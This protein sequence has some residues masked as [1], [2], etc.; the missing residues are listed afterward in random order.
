MI[1][2]PQKKSPSASETEE[3]L[4]SA[5]DKKKLNGITV[6]ADAVEFSQALTSGT[7]VGYITINGNKYT[8]YAPTNTDTTYG[9][10]TSST[11]GLVKSGTDITVDSSGNVSVNDDSHNHVISNIDG[12]QSALDGKAASSHAHDDRYYTESEVDTKLNGKAATSHGN[13][14]PATQTANNAVFLRNDNTWQTVTPANIGAAASSH[15]HS[16]MKGATSSAAGA[17]GLVPAPAAGDQEKFLRADGTWQEAG[18]GGGTSGIYVGTCD[19]DAATAEKAVTVDGDFNLKVGA[20]VMVRFKNTNTAT[21]SYNGSTTGYITLNVNNTG[22]Y[23]IYAEGHDVN[24]NAPYYAKCRYNE[25]GGVAGVYIMYMFNGTYWV[26]LGN[27]S[28]NNSMQ[29][30]DGTA[31]FSH[32]H[33]AKVNTTTA[34]SSESS[35]T[36]RNVCMGTS[37][38]PREDSNYGGPGSIYLVYS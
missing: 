27:S 34:A 26:M 30:Y 8:L 29:S 19:T 32:L 36:V 33:M 16:A 35:Y 3:G 18:G 14:V 9:V 17:A 12:L 28:I 4:M 38:T 37:T 1:F 22:A 7:I 2:Q 6:S 24:G 13:H 23:E 5:A 31:Y 21:T 15:T 20:I 25:C 11:L 10:A